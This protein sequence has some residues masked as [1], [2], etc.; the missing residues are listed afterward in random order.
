VISAIADTSFV[1]A[2]ANEEDFRHDV[3]IS[4]YRQEIK[5]YLMQS[6]LAEV[7][8]LLTRE[9]GNRL[10]ARFL[11]TIPETKYELL[12]LDTIDIQ[13]TGELV[14]QYADS[15]LDFVDASIIAAVE[16]LKISRVLT[17][18]QRDFGIVRPRHTP[19]L[20]LLPS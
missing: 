6:T 15:R 16:R 10:T 3:C 17:L 20:E 11:L 12:P 13:R 9:G 18:D 1:V 7:A 4:V 14:R 5:I 8:Y 19:Y 2:V